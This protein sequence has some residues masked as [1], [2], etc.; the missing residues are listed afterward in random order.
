MASLKSSK[1]S[2]SGKYTPQDSLLLHRALERLGYINKKQKLP[3]PYYVE[4]GV[5]G[6]S[7]VYFLFVPSGDSGIN[8]VAKFDEPERSKREWR[9]I[10][11]LRR[12]NVP[13]HAMLPVSENCPDDRVI[14][15]N[16]T[17]GFST[18]GQSIGLGKYIERQL[19]AAPGNCLAALEQTFNELKLF[20]GG[21]PGAARIANQAEMLKWSD[22]F[23]ALNSP[24][25]QTFLKNIAQKGWSG[26]DWDNEVFKV[27]CYEL[28]NPFEAL[29]QRILGLTGRIMLSRVHG[30]L[31]L[32]NII[33]NPNYAYEPEKAFII[34]LTHSAPN[35]VTAKDLAR[36]ESEFWQEHY[37][38][39]ISQFEEAELLAS[40]ISVRNHLEGRGNARAVVNADLENC[41][42]DFVAILRK[43]AELV[44]KPIGEDDY[45]LNDYFHSLYFSSISA[46]FFKSVKND[47][48]K[49]RLAL[50]SASLALLTLNNLESG[51]YGKGAKKRLFLMHN[52]IAKTKSP[53]N[54]HG[55]IEKQNYRMPEAPSYNYLINRYTKKSPESPSLFQTGIRVFTRDEVERTNDFRSIFLKKQTYGTIDTNLAYIDRKLIDEVY[56]TLKRSTF[57]VLYGN[58]GRGKTFFIFQLIRLV[59]EGYARVLYYSPNFQH[60]IYAVSLLPSMVFEYLKDGTPLL[61][62]MDDGHLV[63]DDIKNELLYMLSS[64]DNLHYLLVSRQK[65]EMIPEKYLHDSLY[66]NFNKIAETTYH[67]ILEIFSSINS[68]EITNGLRADIRDEIETANLVFLTLILLAWQR[69]LSSQKNL[70]FNEVCH[71]AYKD[72]LVYY[73]KDKPRNWRFI[74][75]VVA[76]LFQYEIRIDKN[77][78]TPTHNNK[79]AQHGLESYLIDKLVYK[80]IVNENNKNTPFYV[81]TDFDEGE[82]FDMMRHSSE[83]RF[84]LKAHGKNLTFY[85]AFDHDHLNLDRHEFTKLVLKDYILFEPS[86]IQELQERLRKNCDKWE[87]GDLL[88]YF[89]TDPK[90]NT[91]MET[92]TFDILKKGLLL[93]KSHE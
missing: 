35:S 58:S 51:R 24:E 30:D 9:S 73:E 3:E 13:P 85:D 80:K 33:I 60:D 83:F 59:T 11:E 48:V 29:N 37:A 72:F 53:S 8:L 19:I 77:Y 93:P 5:A 69:K 39:F 50:V 71:I 20:Y 64:H 43:K 7:R 81:F 57:C 21:Q 54:N 44:L 22:I 36:M 42:F 6:R 68:I 4:T 18:T 56:K 74:N 76:A 52:G 28:P 75:H 12:L 79:L 23:L 92:K 66:K 10:N 65:E 70:T 82:E 1:V 90:V 86:N 40:L 25:N 34:D 67:K 87:Y 91:I 78:L 16:A 27:D 2:V 14:I 49:T 26:I 45:L 41:C 32:S 88:M 84:Y 55:K 63:D 61:V 62:I 31:N 46:L 38:T 47:L 17:Q 89:R 15:Y